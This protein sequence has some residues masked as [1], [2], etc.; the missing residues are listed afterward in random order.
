MKMISRDSY[1][2]CKI[3]RKVTHSLGLNSWQILSMSKPTSKVCSPRQKSLKL[4]TRGRRLVTLGLSNSS[5]IWW[6]SPKI[7]RKKTAPSKKRG[8]TLQNQKIKKCT[9]KT[10]RL[11]RK[12]ILARSIAKSSKQSS[13]RPQKT[14][15]LPRELT[16]RTRKEDL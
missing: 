9:K 5:Q 2:T 3:Y 13:S 4:A 15:I 1:N 12:N 10:M 16:R 8:A 6:S 14:I 7:S 11:S